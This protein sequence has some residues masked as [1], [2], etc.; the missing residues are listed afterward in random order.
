MLL[1]LK[2]GFTDHEIAE[3]ERNAVSICWADEKLKGVLLEEINAFAV[4]H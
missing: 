2:G 3:V 4:A 1:R